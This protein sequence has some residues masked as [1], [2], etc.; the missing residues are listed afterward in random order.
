M[1]SYEFRVGTASG[2]YLSSWF[3]SPN[4]AT[5]QHI[6]NGEKKD[7][8]TKPKTILKKEDNAHIFHQQLQQQKTDYSQG[9]LQKPSKP[10]ES[11]K[12]FTHLPMQPTKTANSD[13][14][15]KRQGTSQ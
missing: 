14:G 6:K 1:L 12:L 13:Q 4:N 2:I 5:N 7:Y 8:L 15:S 9:N 11:K 3:D 10:E